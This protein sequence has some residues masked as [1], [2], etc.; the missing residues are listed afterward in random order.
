MVYIYVCVYLRVHI[1]RVCVVNIQG[2]YCKVVFFLA[3]ESGG[4]REER[5]S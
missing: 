5:L 3:G 4:G 1:Y 2:I